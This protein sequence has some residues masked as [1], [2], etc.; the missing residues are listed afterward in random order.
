MEKDFDYIKR[1]EKLIEYLSRE[2]SGPALAIATSKKEK[3]KVTS[4]ELSLLA[5]VERNYVFDKILK[6]NDALKDTINTTQ[7]TQAILLSDFDNPIRK[8][9][10]NLLIKEKLVEEVSNPGYMLTSKGRKVLESSLEL[11]DKVLM[12]IERDAFFGWAYKTLNKD[13]NIN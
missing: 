10:L 3:I 13:N 8:Y 12:D 6:D 5:S 4:L 11:M 2:V 7:Y 1:L 9:V